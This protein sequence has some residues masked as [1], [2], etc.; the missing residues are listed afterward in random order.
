MYSFP[1]FKPY[2]SSM[3]G[4]NCCSLT[5]I[6]VSQ[7]TGKVVWYLHFFNN[8]PKFVVTHTAK[9]FS[10]DNEVDI[11]LESPCFL[12]DPVNAGNLISGSSAFSKSSLYIW[13]FPVHILLKPGLKDFEHSLASMWD[14]S[15]CTVVWTFFCTTLLWVWN[16]NW[17]FLLLWP[18]LCFP[19]LLTYWVQHF[20]SIIFGI[21]NSSAGIPSSP[22]ALFVVMLPKAYLTSHSRMS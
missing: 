1:N 2:S 12:Y 17:P 8:F 11:F 3:S 13:K 22:M 4:S 21:L 5:C 20:N 19:I 15:N 16:E 9:G 18:L 10:V 14:E 6:Q 7:E